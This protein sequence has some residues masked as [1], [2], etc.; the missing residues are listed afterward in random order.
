MLFFAVQAVLIYLR[1]MFLENISYYLPSDV[2][3]NSF[4]EGT[5]GISNQW[6]VERTGILERRRAQPS[7]NSHTMG[8]EA[9][10]RLKETTDLSDVDLIIGA[11]YTPYDTI[12]TL[13]HVIQHELDIADIPVLSVSS[14]CSSFINSAEIVEGY[15]SLG[16]ARKAL[17]V[18]SDHNSAY[19]RDEEP[20]SGPL[21]GDGAAAALFTKDRLSDSAME[22]REVKSAGAATVGKAL[23]GVSLRPKEGLSLPNGKDVFTHA[24]AKMSAITWEILVRNGYSVE[25]LSYIAP[26]QANY[27]ITRKVLENLGV[28]PSKALSNI[29]YLGNTGCA[30]AVIALGEKWHEFKK[31]D[32][33][34]A[35]VFGGGY[36]YGAI[37]MVK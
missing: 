34:V 24:C 32:V 23:E 14:A 9:V 15:F 1:T 2:V 33:V 13:G 12:V 28:D 37:L 17:V 20:K 26:H 11:T 18:A 22:V 36:S 30:G 6:I 16:K 5:S 27:R 10:R 19:S 35:P 21:W 3:P 31:G 4:F 29:E 7:E 25:Q 8:V